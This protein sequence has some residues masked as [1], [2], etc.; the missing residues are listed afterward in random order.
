MNL[1]IFAT[2]PWISKDVTQITYVYSVLHL[3]YME[4]FPIKN[5]YN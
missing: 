1:L 4:E 5:L 2:V 3:L